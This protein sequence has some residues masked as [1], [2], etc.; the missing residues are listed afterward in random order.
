MHCRL[1]CLAPCTFAAADKPGKRSSPL[2]FLPQ[3]DVTIGTT[4]ALIPIPVT[5]VT[6]VR[7]QGCC[8]C[9]ADW[10][11]ISVEEQ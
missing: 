2:P 7:S 5:C 1:P 3:A 4:E 6:S 8:C 10:G 9:D 11:E